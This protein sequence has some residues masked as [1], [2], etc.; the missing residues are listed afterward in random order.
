[1]N[2]LLISSNQEMSDF[3]STHPPFYLSMYDATKQTLTVRKQKFVSYYLLR[4]TYNTF[5]TLYVP[6][7]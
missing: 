2:R 7:V 5:S 4:E 1:M 6:A 3:K